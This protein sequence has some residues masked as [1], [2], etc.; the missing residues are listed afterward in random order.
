[1]KFKAAMNDLK[2]INEQTWRYIMDI[3]KSNKNMKE[4]KKEPERF[5]LWDINHDGNTIGSS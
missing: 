2:D 3:G 1:L 4:K 5:D